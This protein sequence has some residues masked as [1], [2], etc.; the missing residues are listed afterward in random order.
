MNRCLASGDPTVCSQIVRAPSGSLGGTT[1]AGGGYIL[2]TALNTGAAVVSGTD[3][4]VN[5]R[6]LHL[7]RWGA[8]TASLTGTW[9]QHDSTTRYRGAP[10]Y[11]CA[12]LFGD[13]C[14]GGS[15]NPRWRH[16]LR[17]TWESPWRTQLSAQWRFIGG[18]RFDNNSPQPVLQNREEGFFD[19]VL[20]HIAAL[21]YLDLAAVTDLSRTLQVRLG[22][23]NVFD[24]DPPFVPL[25]V[26]G[27][28]GDLNT[29][30]TYD[31]LGR[32]VFVA[33][34]AIF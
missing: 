2:G 8:L 27:R 3:L 26:T 9:L 31:V 14:M 21:S 6:Q 29:Y 15:V 34:R 18:T 7:G 10:T 19:P 30:T 13:T 28:G 20:T 16:N 1:L 33:L 5:Y 17:L 4:Q 22:V 11:D 23:N 12:G 25:D 24:R 32:G